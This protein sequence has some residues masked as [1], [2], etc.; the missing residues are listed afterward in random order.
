M[1]A[2]FDPKI[3]DKLVAAIAREKAK[4]AIVALRIKGEVDANGDLHAA[5]M[6]LR[7]SPSVLFDAVI[8]L[9]GPDGDAQLSADSNAVSFL[10]D[11]E[12]HC[13]AV[14]WAGIPSLSGKAGIAEGE[15]LVAM[16]TKSGVR[17]FVN[18]AK[19]GRFWAREAA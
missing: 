17:D 5:D 16:N 11:A 1:G 8:V 4:A 2:G 13:K 6:A 15:G 9:S 12:R 3:K 19:A 18:A 10:M 7:A 14:G